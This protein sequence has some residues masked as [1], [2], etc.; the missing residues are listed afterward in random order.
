MKYRLAL[1]TIALLAVLHGRA[2]FVN[3]GQDRASL[4]WKQIKTDRF[5][6]IYPDFFEADAQKAANIYNRL[7]SHAN[8]LRVQ[9]RKISM[10]LHADGGVSNG[11]VA[12]APRKSELYTL[13]PQDP[14]DVWLQHLC[15]HEFRHVQQFD[16]INQGMTRGL[17]FLFGDLFPV[18]VMGVYVPM[19]FIEGDAVCFETA[20]GHLGRGRSPE[21][22]NDMKAQIVEKGIYKY[23]KAIL[24]S[25]K[26]H[27]PNRYALGYFM[28]AQARLDYTP[29]IWAQALQ[30]TGRRP[31]GITPFN[32]SL[33]LTMQGRRD[34]LWQSPRVRALFANPDSVRDANTRR[35]PKR[36]LYH[37]NFALLRQ[38]WATE[39]ARTPNRFDTLPTRDKYYT[40]YYY[41]TPTPDGDVIAYR[42][43]LRQPGEF[44]RLNDGAPRLLTR[45]AVPDD[46]K[47]AFNGTQL[48][49]SEYRPHVRW[50]QSGRLNLSRY[51]LQTRKYRRI[52]S[53]HNLLAPF[54]AGGNWGYVEVTR[55][56]K[57]SIVIVDSAFSREICRITAAD[58]ELFIHPS[59]YEGKILTVI[60]SPRGIRLENIDP[61]DGKRQRLTPDAYYELDNPVQLDSL[62]LYRASY[63]GNNALYCHSPQGAAHLLGARFGVRFP[64]ADTTARRLLFSFYTADGYKP[65][66]VPIGSLR[67]TPAQYNRFPLAD[68]L[69]IQENWQT[70]TFPADSLF[71]TRRY[72][73]LPHLVNIHSWGPL[74]ADLY[75]GD[76][77]FGAVIY[78]QNKLSTL[79]FA[80]GYL[81]RSGYDHGAWMLKG[82]YSG[83][84]PVLDFQ[85]ESGRYDYYSLN[86][87]V[88]LRAD[89]AEYL[90]VH[91]KARE[92]SAQLTLRLPLNLSARQYNRTLQP[93]VRYKM[94]GLHGQRPDRL[95]RYH[96]END[97]AWL[98][99]V[100]PGDYRTHTP[101]RLYHLLEYSASFNNATHMSAQEI[102]PR[103]GQTLTAGYTHAPWGNLNPGHQWWTD[104]RLY[105][106]GAAFAHSVTLYGGF[107]H[108]SG[109]ERTYGNKILYP[110]GITLPGYEISSLRCSYSLPLAFP[111]WNIGSLLYLKTLHG[112]LFY[113]RGTSRSLHGT[114][115]YASCGIELTTDS[116]LLNLT[117]PIHWG[118]RTG[119]E[120]QHKRL[121]ADF[122]FSIGLSI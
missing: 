36:T 99:P 8:S 20:V 89:T 2:Q 47:F 105:L 78:S 66:S 118:I 92:S 56:N 75:D 59:W 18:A 50:A 84:W 34:S 83:W 71:P 32:R 81:L 11:N 23:P 35:N 58:D 96:I 30:R 16:K 70:D 31:Y 98:L 101:A 115:R 1:L 6:I 45:T 48:L 121:F 7:Y 67:E 41:P 49:W 102:N 9:P 63:N 77:D 37:D 57:A 39:A 4:R 94:A 107:Q 100:R 104:A 24:G 54:T 106:P 61:A 55:Q 42:Q 114:R 51:D 25:Y 120:T 90:Y 119:Y 43:G 82:T 111:D 97:I 27:V 112:S 52:K 73:K 109:H 38:T 28:T 53:P 10:I 87:G 60:Q 72:R 64:Q 17:S 91:N 76:I 29:D 74:H 95:Y 3:F 88:N 68:S 22:L 116:H 5:Q 26:N 86:R 46:H 15:V 62:L 113:D 69:K 19:W 44:V 12:L 110:R 117:Y 13:P 93:Y 80:A 103:W 33:R 85:L 122:I 21:F 65:G 108:I 14:T 79:S 40:D